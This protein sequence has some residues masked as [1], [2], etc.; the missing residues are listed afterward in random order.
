MINVD[1]II[2]EIL[3][4]EGGWV[5]DPD[6]AGG[7]TNHGI[8]LRYAARVG[9]D[10]DGDGDT[11]ADDIRLVSPEVAAE[12]YKK[13][14]FYGPGIHKLPQVIQAQMVDMAVNMGPPRSIMILQ[15]VL[16]QA[17]DEGVEVDGVIGPKTRSLTVT[18][19]EVMGVF[20]PNALVDER[21]AFYQRL[22]ERKPSQ[23]KFLK[24][25]TARAMEFKEDVDDRLIA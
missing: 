16:R 15:D 6:D 25:W 13:D 18:A 9:L 10:L 21:V 17:L 5:D 12:M 14:F 23:F 20:L 22:C 11:D 7:A 2:H 4:R 8:S 3:R 24:G 19:S 1:E